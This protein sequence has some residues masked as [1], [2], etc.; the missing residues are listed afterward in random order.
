MNYINLA[1]E[2]QIKGL[3]S[4]FSIL[5]REFLFY[6]TWTLIR[7]YWPI[8]PL[9]TLR[10]PERLLQLAW[11]TCLLYHLPLRRHPVSGSLTGVVS[12]RDFTP[13]GLG[14]GSVNCVGPW[15]D[16][17]IFLSHSLY[18]KVTE[19]RNEGK[20]ENEY[21]LPRVWSKSPEGSFLSWLCLSFR[22]SVLTLSV[23]RVLSQSV[24]LLLW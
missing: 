2:T 7:D 20:T 6:L 22:A 11:R 21:I 16:P 4:L 18:K 17:L 15:V 1:P 23:E 10:W 5:L 12:G 13:Q 3:L 24:P 8:L 9:A 19:Q 14:L